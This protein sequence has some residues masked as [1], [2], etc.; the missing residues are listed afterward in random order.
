M[1]KEKEKEYKIL[2]YLDSLGIAHV[3]VNTYLKD[4]RTCSNC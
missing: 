1:K 2:D 4:K 3:D